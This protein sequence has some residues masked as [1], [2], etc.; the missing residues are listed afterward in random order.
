[1]TTALSV[2]LATLLLVGLW[3]GIST[4]A[5]RYRAGLWVPIVGLRNGFTV[6]TLALVGASDPNDIYLRLVALLAAFVS[7]G[8]ETAIWLDVIGASEPGRHSKAA[9]AQGCGA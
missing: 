3:A 9:L 4:R 6:I 2:A 1:M 5:V 7:A 8:I